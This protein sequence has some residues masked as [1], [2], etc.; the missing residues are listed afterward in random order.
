MIGGQ[1]P[2][3]VEMGNLKSVASVLGFVTRSWTGWNGSE[4]RPRAREGAQSFQNGRG[5]QAGGIRQ[6]SISFHSLSHTNSVY[7]K[8]LFSLFLGSV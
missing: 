1:R 2:V 7:H 6:E 3:R 4:C 8:F 5:R